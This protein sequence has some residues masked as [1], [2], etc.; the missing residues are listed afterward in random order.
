MSMVL[1]VR[2]RLDGSHYRRLGGRRADRGRFSWYAIL[3]GYAQKRGQPRGYAYGNEGP[4]RDRDA[5]IT[6]DEE[7][8]RRFRSF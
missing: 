1:M 3:E 5:S 7:V 4:G 6:H 2:W 8:F